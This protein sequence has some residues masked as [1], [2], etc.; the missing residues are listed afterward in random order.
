MGLSDII[1]ALKAADQSYVPPLGFHNAH[2]YRGDYSDLGVEPVAGVSVGDM[3]ETLEAALGCTFEGWKGGS[4]TM[5]D[6]SYVHIAA[7]G[8]VGD[9]IG[10]VLVGYLTGDFSRIP[11]EYGA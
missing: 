11:M 8:N 5:Q 1:A 4:Y 3:V 10:P 6:Y 7:E 9:R 2:S